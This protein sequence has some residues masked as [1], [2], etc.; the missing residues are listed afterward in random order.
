MIWREMYGSGQAMSII[1]SITV[2]CEVEA[3]KTKG[4]IYESGLATV[5]DRVT[6]ALA[7]VFAVPGMGRMIGR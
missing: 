4:I 2:I 1:I 7:L 3:R 5:L 6:T